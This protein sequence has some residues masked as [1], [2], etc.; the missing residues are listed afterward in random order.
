MKG[1]LTALILTLV[2]GMFSTSSL[3][4]QEGLKMGIV[5]IPQSTWMINQQDMEAPL[6]QFDYQLSW[7]MAAGAMV[8]YNFNDHLGFRLNFLY[9]AQGQRYQAK[10]SLDSTINHVRRLNYLKVP[11]MIGFN[12]GTE[13]NKLVFSFHAGYQANVLINANY[14][15]DDESYTPDEALWDDVTDYP[16][17]Y[18]RYSWLA[19]GPVVDFG[20]DIKLTYNVMANIHLRGDYTISDVENKNSAYKLWTNGIPDDVTFYPSDRGITNNLNAGLMIGLT[21]TFSSY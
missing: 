5:A 18:Q 17:N 6:D 11:L 19:H 1:K 10:N 3:F 8:G 13:F 4:A 21:Y 9:S 7:G 16:T 15:N 20:L 14:R 2:A 12:T